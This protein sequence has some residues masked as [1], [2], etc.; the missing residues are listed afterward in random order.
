M[1]RVRVLVYDTEELAKLPVGTIVR[2]HR[3]LGD[4]DGVDILVRQPDGWFGAWDWE[5]AIEPGL[6]VPCTVIATEPVHSAP[7]PTRRETR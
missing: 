6:V 2:A 1:T 4:R 3:D 7:H 5:M